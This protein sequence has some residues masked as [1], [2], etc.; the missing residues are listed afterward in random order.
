M[1]GEGHTLF[2]FPISFMLTNCL[3]V[4][5]HLECLLIFYFPTTLFMMMSVAPERLFT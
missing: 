5:K 1:T 4:V 3:G 2:A